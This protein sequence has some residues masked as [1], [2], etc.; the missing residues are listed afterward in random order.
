MENTFKVEALSV[1]RRRVL[2]CAVEKRRKLDKTTG[3]LAVLITAV[4]PTV[5]GKVNPLP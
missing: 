3:I 1:E 2:P 5:L 4:F